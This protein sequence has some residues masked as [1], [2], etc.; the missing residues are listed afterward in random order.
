[1]KTI[2]G[3]IILVNDEKYERA[4]LE[5]ALKEKNW[6]VTI[7]YFM[8]AESALAYLRETKDEIFLIISDIGMPKINGLEFK[9]IID[10]DAVLSRKALPFIFASSAATKEQITEAYHY[11]V[12]GYFQKPHT[13]SLQAEMVD[14]I[15]NYWIISKHPNQ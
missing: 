9:K 8:N 14:V 3:K 6:N 4:L 7:E 15:I 5:L 1:M 11:R 2:K 12:Q 13:V 10:D